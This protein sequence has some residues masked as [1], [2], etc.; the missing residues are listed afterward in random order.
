MA[1]DLDSMLDKAEA[2]I[3]IG[4]P[5]LFALEER[6]NRFERTG[7]ELVYHDLAHEWHSLTGLPFVSAVWGAAQR[8]PFG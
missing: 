5:A 6:S 1:A 2:A 3:V 7:E 4:D 8:Q